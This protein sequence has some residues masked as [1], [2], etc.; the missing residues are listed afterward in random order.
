MSLPV[1]GSLMIEPTESEDLGELN[2][3]A[4]ALIQIKEEVNKVKSGQFD[5]LDNPL[6]NAPH[7]QAHCTA[8]EWNHKYTREE[9][10]NSI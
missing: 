5:K 8:T 7:T 2:R 10:F 3:F 4:D 1:S 9:G 6:K